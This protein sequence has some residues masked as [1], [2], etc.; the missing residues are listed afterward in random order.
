MSGILKTVAGPVGTLLGGQ[1]F[2]GIAKAIG[3]APKPPPVA[4][5]P[6]PGNPAIIAARRKAAAD[7]ASRSGRSS[8]ILSNGPGGG[9]YSSP[10][11]G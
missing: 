6:D 3:G 4:T 5:M 10:V 7:A 9:D 2:S 1:L 11:M 8:T